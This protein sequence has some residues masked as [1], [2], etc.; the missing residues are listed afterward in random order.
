MNIQGYED[1]IIY[2]DGDIYSRKV[3]RYLIIKPSKDG[4]K[5]SSLHKNGTRKGF[6]VHRLIALH[7]IDNPDNKPHIDHI[8]GNPLNNNVENLRWVTKQENDNAF[9][10]IQSNNTSGI[11]NV[12]YDKTTNK[13]R[14][15]K[16]IFGERI[17]KLFKTKQEA[18]WFKFTF[19]L[20]HPQF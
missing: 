3:N 11:K 10:T 16:K 17:Q 2:P 13:W 8:D 12:S 9:R 6:L 14:Y 1:Y 5:R 4:Y 7:Y 20:L 19:E 15:D 18:L